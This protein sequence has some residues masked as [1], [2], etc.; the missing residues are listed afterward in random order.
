[1]ANFYATY[2]GGGG[3]G[4]GGGG[5]TTLGALDSQLPTAQGADISGSVLSMQSATALFPGLVNNTT[6]S[7]SGNKTFTG[8]ISASNLSGTNT[9][10]VTI[11]T[12]N[13]LSI[14]AGQILSLGLS[15]TS[16]TGALSSTDWN[17]FNSK[18]T[19]P[20][21]T[22]GSVVFSN[23]TTLAQDNSNFFWDDTNNRLG[24]GTNTPG[25]DVEI[26]SAQG[27]TNYFALSNAT[28]SS[29]F[30]SYVDNNT[31][32]FSKFAGNAFNNVVLNPNGVNTFTGNLTAQGSAAV[33]DIVTSK[34]TPM[35]GQTSHLQ[36]WNNSQMAYLPS[37]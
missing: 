30:L 21:L 4:G 8:T 9:G 3:G 7:F 17:T 15:S 2:S 5:V 11:G 10:D 19:L 25:Y 28:G 36:D 18:F 1:M 32:L 37:S 35:A 34:V 20:A 26:K 27:G 13:G 24:I 14:A 29:K 16:T 12:A 6:Q 33:G 22:A 23:G 31:I